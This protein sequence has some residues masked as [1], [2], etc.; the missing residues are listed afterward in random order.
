MFS[1]RPKNLIFCAFSFYLL[2]QLLLFSLS[3]A[4]DI[5]RKGGYVGSKACQ[6]CHEQEYQNYV[7]YARKSKSFSSVLKMKKGLTQEEIRK[8]YSC[9]TTGYGK[10]GGFISLEETP[11]LK[12]AGCEVCHGPG[13]AHAESGDPAYIEEKVGLKTCQVCHTPERVK[14]FRYK[15]LIHGGGH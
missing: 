6:D 10:P 5:G 7:K 2:A 8:C 1:I 4:E 11:D 12:D 13:K 9:H 3:W 15:P 14:A